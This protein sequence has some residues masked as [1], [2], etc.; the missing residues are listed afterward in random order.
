[1]TFIFLNVRN[2]ARLD[3]QCQALMVQ[4]SSGDCMPH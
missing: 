1:M 2:V 4:V 3:A